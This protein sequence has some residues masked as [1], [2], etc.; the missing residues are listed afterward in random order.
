MF[1][2]VTGVAKEKH[3]LKTF[4]LSG[5]VQ[6]SIE[7]VFTKS[8]ESQWQLENAMKIVRIIICLIQFSLL[9]RL[10]NIKVLLK[11]RRGWEVE[12]ARRHSQ[13]TTHY[14]LL[15]KVKGDFLCQGGIAPQAFNSTIRLGLF[16]RVA[17]EIIASHMHITAVKFEQNQNRTFL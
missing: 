17:T 2:W 7:V 8:L 6:C 4:S 3:F 13:S 10:V 12:V 9:L 15:S 5:G 16:W 1:L 14:T 11:S